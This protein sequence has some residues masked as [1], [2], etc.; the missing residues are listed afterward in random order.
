VDGFVRRHR[1]DCSVALI[2]AALAE[3]R[4]AIGSAK[5]HRLAIQVDQNDPAVMN[6]G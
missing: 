2:S 3:N 6:L 1:S 5:P 4:K